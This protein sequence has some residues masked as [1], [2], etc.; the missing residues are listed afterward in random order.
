MVIFYGAFKMDGSLLF[1]FL[2]VLFTSD[3]NILFV[4]MARAILI[5]QEEKPDWPNT[6][7]NFISQAMAHDILQTV[8]ELALIGKLAQADFNRMFVLR[9]LSMSL[10]S[11]IYQTLCDSDT[12]KQLDSGVNMSMFSRYCNCTCSVVMLEGILAIVG[13]SAIPFLYVF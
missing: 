12:V 1:R 2:G 11:C 10:S 9:D 4:T 7:N 3:R 6:F 13:S 8:V 5:F